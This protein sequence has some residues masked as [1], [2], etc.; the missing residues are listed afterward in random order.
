MTTARYRHVLPQLGDKLFLTDGGIETTLIFHQGQ[1]LPHFAAF[2]LMRSREGQAELARY[3]APYVAL[4][5]EH[6]RGLV[7]ESAT[8][9]S[10]PE[11]GARLGYSP[12]ALDAVNVDAIALIRGI[13]DAEETPESP[14]VLSGCLGPR[15]DGYA[16]DSYMSAEEAEAY[17]GRQVRVFEAA[18]ADMVT[19]ITMTYVNEAV[20]IVRAARAAGMPVAISFT[21]ETDACLRDGTP[22]GA[23][24]EACDAATGG[25]PAYYMVNC[26]H[27]THF[28]AE[29]GAGAWR[30][31]IRGI[32]ANA[33]KMS[34]AELDE[35]PVLDDGDPEELGQDYRRL[36]ALLPNLT[37]LGGC[38]GT[39][40]RH[41]GAISHACDRHRHAA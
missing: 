16:P 13:R 2:D 19:A 39:D 34:H 6:R 41:I 27:P 30:E 18:G 15:G 24:I 23:A 38:C 12:E 28:R 9:R 7:L 20:G 11:W 26:A 37:V 35:S 32:R 29:L 33:S 3:Y 8:W 5:R 17:H 40:V 21:V 14:M 31:R 10:N 25:F 36:M 1:E 22:L 4:A